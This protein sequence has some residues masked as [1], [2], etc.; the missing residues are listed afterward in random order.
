LQGYID[1]AQAV[2]NAQWFPMAPVS[3]ISIVRFGCCSTAMVAGVVTGLGLPSQAQISGVP[4]GTTLIVFPS[5]APGCVMSSCFGIDGGETHGENLFHSFSQFDVSAGQQVLFDHTGGIEHIFGR[6]LDDGRLSQ[7]D[8]LLTTNGASLYLLNRNGFIFGPNAR[9]N[10]AD[11]FVASTG[12]RFL[13]SVSSPESGNVSVLPSET[14]DYFSVSPDFLR[15]R[16]SSSLNSAKIQL[17]GNGATNS[18]LNPLPG[19][20]VAFIAG[21]LEIRDYTIHVPENQLVLGGF[22]QDIGA[23]SLDRSLISLSG[24]VSS[25]NLASVANLEISNSLLIPN[26]AVNNGEVRVRAYNVNITNS[27]IHTLSD[28]PQSSNDGQIRFSVEGGAFS[29]GNSELVTRAETDNSAGKIELIGPDTIVLEKSRWEV[30]SDNVLADSNRSKI[31]ANSPLINDIELRHNSSISVF[32]GER[33]TGDS[34]QISLRANDQISLDGNSFVQTQSLAI[35]PGVNSGLISLESE[36][37]QLSDSKVLATTE[38]GGGNI[39]LIA[40]GLKLKDS[41]LIETKTQGAGG[42]I[43]IDI[44]QEFQHLSSSLIQATADEPGAG[45]ITIQANQLDSAPNNNADILFAGLND[46]SRLSLTANYDTALFV[47]AG[48]NP[49]QEPPNQLG[50]A[51]TLTPLPPTPVP[52]TPTPV[53]PTPTPVSEPPGSPLELEELVSEMPDWLTLLFASEESAENEDLAENEVL[54]SLQDRGSQR[55]VER[56]CAGRDESSRSQFLISNRG[57]IPTPPSNWIT[58]RSI[59]DLGSVEQVGATPSVAVWATGDRVPMGPGSGKVQSMALREATTWQRN[60]QGQIVL[61][62][63]RDLLA[64]GSPSCAEG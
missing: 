5:S 18:I 35:A 29:M 60:G 3:M 34:G 63:S 27:K 23:V 43:D 21:D 54:L 42:N 8:G 41:S 13:T 11:T 16:F 10:I 19:R 22:K 62:G 48:A 26:G 55:Q 6:V 58:Q 45:V 30:H 50:Y 9:I 20:A 47:E 61:G 25:S 36:E 1:K 57:G 15:I 17:L 40:G 64:P 2:M 14:P 32:L 44:D 7:I 4:G 31:I 49:R 37:I 53:P 56:G 51:D 46:R 59:A 38:V 12:D 39:S 28:S 33:A 52:P 24:N